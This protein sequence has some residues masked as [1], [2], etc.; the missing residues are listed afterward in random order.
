MIQIEL[1]DVVSRII[2]F[3]RPYIQESVEL[4]ELVEDAATLVWLDTCLVWHLLNE[5]DHPCLIFLL[6]FVVNESQLRVFWVFWA[7]EWIIDVI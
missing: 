5:E 4:Q 2:L 7:Q 1:F 6:E 3:D